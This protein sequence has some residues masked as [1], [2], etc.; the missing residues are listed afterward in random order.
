M[1]K[2]LMVNHGDEIFLVIE[3]S[4]YTADVARPELNW[5]REPWI[6]TRFVDP[7]LHSYH[8]D[9][10]VSKVITPASSIEHILSKSCV[11]YFSTAL[12]DDILYHVMSMLMNKHVFRIWSFFNHTLP[13]CWQLVLKMLA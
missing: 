2:T 8:L 11:K 4:Y 1:L 5:K 13:Q 12:S 9:I 10:P 3:E 6:I 7:L